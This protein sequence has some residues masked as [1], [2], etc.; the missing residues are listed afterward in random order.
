LLFPF[1]EMQ[2]ESRLNSHWYFFDEPFG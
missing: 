1:L 2:P